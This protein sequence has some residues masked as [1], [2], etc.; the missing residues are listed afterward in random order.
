LLVGYAVSINV[1]ILARFPLT[2]T[3]LIVGIGK[4]KRIPGFLV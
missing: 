3:T 1:I 4:I 2:I